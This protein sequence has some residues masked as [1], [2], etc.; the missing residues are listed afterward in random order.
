[1]RALLALRLALALLLPL[2]AG[3]II[4][5]GLCASPEI[6]VPSNGTH[7]DCQHSLGGWDKLEVQYVDYRPAAPK[8]HL[9][10]N[11]LR[12]KPPATVAATVMPW[13]QQSTATARQNK[14]VVEIH[15]RWLRACKTNNCWWLQ[16]ALAMCHVFQCAMSG[17]VPHL[18]MCHVTHQ[19]A[20]PV[21]STVGNRCLT[22]SSPCSKV[23]PSTKRLAY[24]RKSGV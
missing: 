20:D 19:Y 5:L 15:T 7:V 9:E 21:I 6:G 23:L 12:T 17:K 16:Q 2:R 11:V 1:M 22:L 3:D 4:T 14:E 18:A 13:P 8:A 24:I 10:R